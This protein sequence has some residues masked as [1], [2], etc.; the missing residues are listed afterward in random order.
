MDENEILGFDP[1]SLNVFNENTKTN[2]GNPLIY[3][4][5][6]ADS[7]SKDGV[8]RS[9]IKVI[10]NPFDFRNSVLEQQSYAL[11]DA[12]G[13]FNVV[14]SLTNGDTSCPIFKAWKKCHYATEGSILNKLITTEPK[15][16][17][18]RYARYCVV[19]IMEDKNQPDL[20]GQYMFWKL[21]K[22][23]W[24]IIS[25][26][27]NPSKESGKAPIPVM[28]FL[29]G[30]SIDLEVSPG[31]DDP[32]APERKTR[33]TSYMGEISENV[34]SC[35]NPDGTS[36]IT[37]D[38]QKVL[39][40]YISAMS[41]V[42]ACKNA[43]ERESLKATIDADENTK[44]LKKIYSKVLVAIK[45]FCPNLIET[46]GYKEFTPEIATRVNN[47][48]EIVLGGNNP[49][50]VSDVPSVLTETK[51]STSNVSVETGTC[52]APTEQSSSV[53]DDLPF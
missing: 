53:D 28:D 49:A 34:T 15:I 3:H 42:W 25:T 8:Y 39:D 41:K 1:T 7:K 18:K 11:Q 9:T 43:D 13:Y 12:N 31:P 4:T 10:Y 52:D 5:R 27:A 22:S 38:E 48:I 45:S 14:S 17:D 44:E 21:P 16:F 35:T 33:E 2:S 51:Q 37:D 29:F 50:S 40:A 6:P 24:D 23:I 32:K 46:L 30:R 19:Q 26:K 47:W 36:L 20:V